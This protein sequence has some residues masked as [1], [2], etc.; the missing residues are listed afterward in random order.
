MEN[1]ENRK[2]EIKTIGIKGMSCKSCVSK[3]EDALNELK[4]VETAKV[5]LLEEQAVVVFNPDMI[6]ADRIESR[7]KELGY[8]VDA[9]K[10]EA[11]EE[12][13]DDE[14]D[15][16]IEAGNNNPTF[17]KSLEPDMEKKKP[18]TIM[19]G[20]TYGLM[21]HIGCIAFIL[22][23][24]LGVTAATSLFTPLLLNPYFFYILIAMSFGFATISIAIYLKRNGLLSWKGASHKWK[25]IS[26]MYGTTIGVNLLLFLVIFPYAANAATIPSSQNGITGA[27]IGLQSNLASMKLQ[28]EIPCSGHALLISE[29]LKKISGVAGVQFSFPNYFDVKYDPSKTSKTEIL[30]LEVFKTYAAKVVSESNPV[31][32]PSGAA[33]ALSGSSGGNVQT[34]KLS[35]SGGNY[36]LEPS[37]FKKG[38]PVRL[39]ADLSKMPGCSKSVVISAFNVNK[40]LAPGDNVIEFT[41]DKAGTFNIACSMNMYKGTFTVLEPDGTRSNYAQPSSSSGGSCGGGSGGGCGGCGG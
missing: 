7:I 5:N 25:Y 31:S 16:G 35:V 32:A 30:A 19:Q 12:A 37:T 20:I 1:K 17:R 4:G 24:V 21:P 6:A 15:D 22:F 28:V 13:E 23:S 41:P 40:Y 34:V 27:A 38:V 14:A 33:V 9:A 3:I 39:E 36:V 11:Q 2:S 29:E 10:Q 8:K 18:S 26:T